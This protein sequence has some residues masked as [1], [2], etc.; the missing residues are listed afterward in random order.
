MTDDVLLWRASVAI[1]LPIAWPGLPDRWILAQVQAESAG[2]PTAVSPVGAAGLLQLMPAT[3]RELG[4]FV[5]PESDERLDPQANL[6]AGISYL[7]RQYDAL[8]EV[9]NPTERLLW[10]FA[11]YNCG[12]GFVDFDGGVVYDTCLELARRDS[13][14]DWWKWDVGRYW[15]MHYACIRG[16]RHPDY[17]QVWD[18]VA[19][20]RALAEAA[21]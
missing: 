15:L 17:R 12:R 2:D 8:G 9:P 10:A 14:D 4:L 1:V 19:R 11:A 21:E 20:I 18:Y 7:K 5:G 3:A 6:R 13:P 16:G